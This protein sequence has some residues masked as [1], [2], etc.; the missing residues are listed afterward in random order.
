MPI[1]TKVKSM[2]TELP[3]IVNNYTS[4][5]RQNLYFQSKKKK[6]SDKGCHSQKCTGKY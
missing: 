5:K 3:Q 2:N 1:C 6:S 4:F